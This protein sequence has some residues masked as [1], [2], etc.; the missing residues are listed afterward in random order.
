MVQKEQLKAQKKAVTTSKKRA[1][2]ASPTG[3][4]SQLDLDG[5]AA[6]SGAPPRPKS[7]ATPAKAAGGKSPN[8]V[9]KVPIHPTS[10]PTNISD[11]QG[12]LAI[13]RALTSAP[14]VGMT[15]EAL[16]RTVAR[17][18]TYAMNSPGLSQALDA[19]IRRAVRRGIAKNT[20]GNLSLLVHKI[21]DYDL[22][23]LKA[24]LLTALRAQD[25]SC[26]K[27]E[28]PKLLARFLGFARTGKNITAM[29][30]K[31]LRSLI[32]SN[33]VESKAG[34]IRVLR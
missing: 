25:G 17:D 27:A 12:M 6:A 34:L 13:R 23:H 22:D 7:R 2:S 14:T 19:A 5:L 21:D 8:S 20:V 3:A 18:L 15:R 4:N 24:Q 31:I 32:R 29:V 16:I 9:A 1:S 30:E 10:K 28:A 33:Q 26:P 11:T